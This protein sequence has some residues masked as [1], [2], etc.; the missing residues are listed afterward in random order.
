MHGQLFQLHTQK[1]D[2]RLLKEIFNTANSVYDILLYR[3]LW[4]TNLVNGK[5]NYSHIFFNL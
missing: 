2:E 5:H 4:N 1:L 3:T